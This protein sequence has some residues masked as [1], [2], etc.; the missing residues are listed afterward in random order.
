VGA[1]VDLAAVP[2]ARDTIWRWPG[3][4]WIWRFS[5]GEDYELLFC[6]PAGSHSP[7]LSAAGS[8]SRSIASDGSSTADA[9]FA[10]RRRWRLTPAA[11]PRGWDQL[12]SEGR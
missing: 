4:G 10:S 2:R 6:L 1:E 12:G 9:G 11:G 8:E 7:Q 3:I 5:G